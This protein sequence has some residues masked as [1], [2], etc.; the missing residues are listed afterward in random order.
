MRKGEGRVC[1]GDYLL[2]GACSGVRTR[3]LSK[4]VQ[5]DIFSSEKRMEASCSANWPRA[6]RRQGSLLACSPV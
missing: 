6:S 3:I 1:G 4:M 2:Q 5:S